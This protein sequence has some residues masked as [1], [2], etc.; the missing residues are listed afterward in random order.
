MLDF[1]RQTQVLQRVPNPTGQ[2][3][4]TKQR[5]KPLVQ[6]W[7]EGS[8]L[9]EQR[10]ICSISG[11]ILAWSAD[12]G[13]GDW[14]FLLSAGPFLSLRDRVQVWFSKVKYT[15][16]SAWLIA[17]AVTRKIRTQQLQTLFKTMASAYGVKPWG[18]IPGCWWGQSHRGGFTV[19]QT[20]EERVAGQVTTCTDLS[21]FTPWMTKKD[22]KT[23]RMTLDSGWKKT[24]AQR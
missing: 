9:Q 7:A 13:G 3:G 17:S 5:K 4:R 2:F 1:I 12:G 11:D 14:K 15:P 18:L 20:K 24:S 10:G 8:D 6:N 21:K 19:G 23:V 22:S 16:G